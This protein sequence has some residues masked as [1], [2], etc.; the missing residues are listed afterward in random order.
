M[1]MNTYHFVEDLKIDIIIIGQKLK[2]IQSELNNKNCF[3]SPPV[4]LNERIIFSPI[5]DNRLVL[6]FISTVNSN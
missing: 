6:L 2:H 1:L 3:S 4:Q 5:F